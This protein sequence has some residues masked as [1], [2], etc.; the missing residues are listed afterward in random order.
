MNKIL[1]L[2][3]GVA[4]AA[5]VA[6]GQT[7]VLS[8]NAVGYVKVTIPDG[9]L[10]LIR[11]DFEQL[12]PS[13]P[14]DMN[15]LIGDQLPNGSQAHIWDVG[16]SAYVTELKGGRAGAWPNP[17]RVVERGE[18]FWLEIPDSSGQADWDVYIMGEVPGANNNSETSSVL[19]IS[20]VDAV[21]YPFP[22]AIVWGETSLATNLPLD[23][24]LHL[25]NID[26]QSYES[27]LKGGRGGDWGAAE[28]KV[29]EPGTAF[30]VEVGDASVIDWT[31]AKPYNWP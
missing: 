23:S 3:L 25:W 13:V 5:P 22:A 17:G 27:F 30:W 8:Q 19:A 21:G 1:G 26:T 18:A 11:P 4:L 29:I 31:E 24:L 14:A 6:F 10:A 16:T 2:A 12:D 20:G 9:G 28:T 7:N 15:N